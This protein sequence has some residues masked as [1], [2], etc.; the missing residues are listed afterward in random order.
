MSS[1]IT[2]DAA[3]A[4]DPPPR[5]WR[6]WWLAR[7]KW[8]RIAC[9]TLLTLFV[10]NVALMLRI[11][12]G[13]IE[14]PEISRLRQRGIEF[15]YCW[16][17]YEYSRLPYS[18]WVWPGLLGKSGLNV[19]SVDVGSWNVGR[20]LNLKQIAAKY[21]N[22]ESLHLPGVP[23]TPEGLTALSKCRKLHLLSLHETNIDDQGVE[24]LSLLPELDSLNLGGTH[25]TDAVI[26]TLKEMK[27]LKTVFVWNTDVTLE[28]VQS[29]RSSRTDHPIK[30]R[31]ELDGKDLGVYATVRWSDGLRDS[32]F[33]DGRG[34]LEVV[35]TSSAGQ[36]VFR[37]T[38]P[39]LQNFYNA[40]LL[41]ELSKFPDGEYRL[42]LRY[43][44]LT[45]GP[46]V[47]LM[48]QGVP[49][50]RF[51]E[52]QLPITRADGLKRLRQ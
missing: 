42:T 29:L 35:G 30:V 21:P 3:V 45:A 49:S 48:E 36:V 4:H 25:V 11:A 44:D 28:A 7:P 27:K 46:I 31:T 8:L 22:A 47:L 34:T 41:K 5:T 51:V 40:W 39:R 12:I 24:K 23:I 17:T 19:R 38:Y 16:E 2:L 13:W 26:P 50:Q 18:E 43:D 1:Q 15:T 6:G 32:V 9:W 14:D 37:E 52:F 33:P 20:Q 10:L